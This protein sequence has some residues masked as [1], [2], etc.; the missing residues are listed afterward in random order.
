VDFEDRPLQPQGQHVARMADI[1][2]AT[3]DDD[4]Q[5]DLDD[6]GYG[7]DLGPSDGIGSRD[8]DI[9]LG[10]DF[11]DGP[12]S[13][14]ENDDMSVEQGR[15]AAAPRHSLD[16]HIFGN[17]GR[18]KEFDLLSNRSRGASEHPFG[19]EMDMD[20]GPDF[21]GIDLGVNFG[22][23]DREKTPGQTRSPSRACM[24]FMRVF[25]SL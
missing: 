15:E 12:V 4:L 9:D 18:D 5:F 25:L 19:A 3:A 24:W 17:D 1:T 23:N 14:H 16:S 8:Y 10:L 7:F 6:P 21:A 2:L 11:G 22:D 13:A 20:F